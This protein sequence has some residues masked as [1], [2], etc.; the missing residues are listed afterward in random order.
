MILEEGTCRNNFWW[1]REGIGGPLLI[2]ISLSLQYTGPSLPAA[3]SKPCLTSE[4]PGG[5]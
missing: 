3:S 2:L 5:L 4:P 1:E